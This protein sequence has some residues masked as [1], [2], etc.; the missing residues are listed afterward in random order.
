MGIS[1]VWKEAANEL[2]DAE[3]I[4]IIGYSLPETDAFF[5][6]LYA[7]GTVGEKPLKRFWVFDPDSTGVV[8]ERFISL[9]GPGARDR[10]LFFEKRFSEAIPLIRTAFR[11]FPT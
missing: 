6:Y 7:L 5:R 4:F 2:G 8:E 1:K 10:F 11:D 9:L 3:N